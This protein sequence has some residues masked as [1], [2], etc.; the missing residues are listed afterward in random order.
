[1]YKDLEGVGSDLFRDAIL[2][3]AFED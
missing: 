3:F 2:I 1:M